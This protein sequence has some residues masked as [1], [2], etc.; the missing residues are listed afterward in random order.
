MTRKGKHIVLQ[1]P[2]VMVDD[3]PRF[4]SIMHL[5]NNP[6]LWSIA[7][8]QDRLYLAHIQAVPDAH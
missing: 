3:V 5:W 8:A 7:T 6:F 4:Q 1:S 2:F